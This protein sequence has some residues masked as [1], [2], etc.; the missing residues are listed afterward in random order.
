[1]VDLPKTKFVTKLCLKIN[2]SFFYF[3]KKKKA[4][5]EIEIWN[6]ASIT[7]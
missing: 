5:F 7:V 2:T 6:I 3:K 4:P 1:M